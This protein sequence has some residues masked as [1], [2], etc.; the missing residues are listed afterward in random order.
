MD[1]VPCTACQQPIAVSGPG[2]V[3]DF[4]SAPHWAPFI[5]DLRS[6][7]HEIRHPACFAREAGVEQ[8]VEL[9]HEHDVVMREDSFRSWQMIQDLKSQ[10]EK[11]G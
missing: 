9:V 5:E 10:L 2:V 1:H 4:G 3:N 6:S 11:G 7:A 8:L